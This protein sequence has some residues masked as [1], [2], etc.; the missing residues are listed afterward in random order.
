MTPPLINFARKTPLAA[1]KHRSYGTS[2]PHL[3]RG[4]L[5][6]LPLIKSQINVPACRPGGNSFLLS[7]FNWLFFLS[8][9]PDVLLASEGDLL[10]ESEISLAPTERKIEHGTR[11]C[12]RKLI[13][14][15]NVKKRG[16]DQGTNT[17]E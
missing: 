8:T 15:D 2:R 12:L 10:K 6:P 16:E 7:F 1:D 13:N 14:E 9:S 3:P 4:A 11:G 17:N 5:L